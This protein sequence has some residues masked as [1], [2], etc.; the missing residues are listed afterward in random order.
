MIF[1]RLN[2]LLD[3]TKYVGNKRAAIHVGFWVFWF[4][5]IWYYTPNNFLPRQFNYDLYLLITIRDFLLVIVCFYLTSVLIFQKVTEG[6]WFFALIAGVFLYFVFYTTNF[7]TLTYFTALF[8]TH[9]IHAN[10][11]KLFTEYGFWGGVFTRWCFW[12]ITFWYAIYLIVPI[13][14][15]L[16]LDVIAFRTRNLKLERDNIRLELDYLKSQVNPHFLFNVLNSIYSTVIDSEPQAAQIIL[17]L[18]AM[19]RYSLYE[20]NSDRVE[21]N[22]EI[23]FIQDYIELEQIRHQKKTKISFTLEGNPENFQIPPLML[24]SFVENA[25]KH[26]VNTTIK[27][28]WVDVRLE[29]VET[30]L[31]FNIAN[32]KPPKVAQ[33][34]QNGGIGIINI[35]KRLELIYPQ[36]HSLA[37][38]STPEAYEVCLKIVL[39]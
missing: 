37:I 14:I 23:Q 5:F 28:S 20:T 3:E 30:T 15:K 9:A 38:N 1:E 35:K 29:V 32:S 24:I 19:M 2:N 39:S 4:F 7:Y 31:I 16:L 26:G 34:A 11:T 25:F 13:V 8:P 27:K 21:L 18:S 10:Y 17:K 6:K 33:E 22:R 36:K 12:H